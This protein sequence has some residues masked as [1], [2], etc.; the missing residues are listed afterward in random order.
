MGYSHVRSTPPDGYN[1]VWNSNSISTVFH[2]GNID[3]DYRA[4]EPVAR[5]GM[6][7]PALAVRTDSGWATLADFAAA[8]RTKRMR[9]GISGRGSFVHL[10][11]VALFDKLG[12]EVTYVP[13]GQGTAPAELLGGRVDAALQWP[14]QFKAQADANELRVIAVT[15]A[16]RIPVMPD[17]PTAK[18]QGYDVDL[19]MWRGLAA[20]KG[21]PKDVIAKLEGAVRNVVNSPRFKELSA[22]LGFEPGFLPAAEFG[23]LVADDDMAIAGLMKQL[24]L[25]EPRTLVRCASTACRPHPGTHPPARGAGLA[26]ARVHLS[27]PAPRG[28]GETG[29][30][31]FP[32]LLG[33]VARRPRD[34]AGAESGPRRR[35]GCAGHTPRGGDRRRHD[36]GAGAL[37]LPARTGGL[38]DR[39]A[40]R[41]RAHDVGPGARA[42]CHAHRGP[43]DRV[44]RRLLGDLRRAPGHAAAARFMGPLAA[45]TPEAIAATATGAI[46]GL[47]FSAIPGLTFSTALALMMPFTFGLDTV[48]AIGMLLGIYSGGM[49]GGAVASILLGI[50]GNPS[51]AATV[52]DGYQMAR[53]GQASLALG[54]SVVASAFGGLFSLIVMM[55]LIEQV[56][57]VAIRFGPA[58]IFALVLFGLSTICGLAERS[59]L[60][61]LVAGVLGLMMMTI[62]LDELDGV[63]RLTFGTIQLQQGINVLVAMIALFAVPQVIKTFIDHGTPADSA[64]GRERDHRA[65][66]RNSSGATARCRT[67]GSWCAVP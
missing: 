6:E 53:K 39:D 65:G 55:L 24:G 10:V 56:A 43:G 12:V 38:P 58:E 41:D 50:P 61:G 47:V 31:A 42:E 63:G 20:P 64:P 27:F 28:A 26:V 60:R 19:V 18:E 54:A 1:I 62:G 23:A 45:L 15:S 32:V 3:F 51:A 29:P 34:R 36:R 37:R 9:V 40:R 52:F 14:S 46:V 35:S 57:A 25:S 48:P 2:G 21:T 7:V 66:A 30:R 16:E 17:V 4:F 33:V 13:Y 22:S 49:T 11:S 67:G 8:A 59:M 44:H 5:V